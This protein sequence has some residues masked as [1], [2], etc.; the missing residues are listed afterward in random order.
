M[1]RLSVELHRYFFEEERSEGVILADI[2]LL[3]GERIFGFLFVFLALPSA[4]PL[5]APG[6]STPFG[7]VIFILAVQ[8]VAGAQRPWMPNR[9]MNYP[10]ALSK[11]QG[12]LKAGIPWLE[13]IELLSRPR[14]TYMCTTLGGR[15]VIGSAIALMAISMMI[16][17]PGTNTLPAMGIFVT[18]FGLLDDDGAITLAGLVLC[19]MGFILSSSILMALWFGGSSLLDIIQN[20]LA[21]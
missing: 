4:L 19:V 8:L 7:I 9:V 18:G 10:I 17:I 2:I 15:V 13:K 1:A 12:I 20:W 6:Y 11:V 5:P 16:P 14:L 21:Q 3:A